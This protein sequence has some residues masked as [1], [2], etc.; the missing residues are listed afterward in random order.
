MAVENQ[1][2]II[3]NMETYFQVEEILVV[4]NLTPASSTKPNKKND[5]A[6]NPL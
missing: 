5:A 1:K 2:S 4:N 6:P 3:N